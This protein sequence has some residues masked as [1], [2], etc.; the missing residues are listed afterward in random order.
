MLNKPDV[1][2]E[3]IL[4]LAEHMLTVK[5]YD[6]NEWEHCICGQAQL[7]WDL[8][9]RDDV[10]GVLGISPSQAN[11]LFGAFHQEHKPTRENAARVLRHLAITGT[12]DWRF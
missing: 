9:Q 10:Y 5:D 3:N 12:V 1:H 4:K 7:L 6:Q 2:T 8:H 11:E